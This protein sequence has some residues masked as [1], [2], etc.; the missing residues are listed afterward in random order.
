MG[1]GVDAVE[2]EFVLQH[3]LAR[4]NQHGQIFGTATC[5]D[6]VDRDL[7]DRRLAR[8]FDDEGTQLVQVLQ[9]E[10]G[11]HVDQALGA[12][13]VAGRGGEHC[14]YTPIED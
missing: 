12:G 1:G 2:I 11:H 8:G 7:L 10:L 13:V 9:L 14:F 4:G 3:R 5:H 6:C